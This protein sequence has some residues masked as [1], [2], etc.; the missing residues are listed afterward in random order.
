MSQIINQ[1]V[2]FEASP[3]HVYQA[4]MNAEQH[5]AFT[6]SAAKISTEPGG[7]WSAYG[8]GVHGR[9]IELVPDQRIVQAW[10]AASWPAGT[11]SIV[12]IELEAHDDKT[13]LRLTHSALPSEGAEHIDEGW[14]LRYWRPLTAWLGTRD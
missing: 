2:Q 4:L 8:G 1:E 3:A 12:R 6:G 5:S 10:R 9:N 13:K 11:Y 14:R 7:E